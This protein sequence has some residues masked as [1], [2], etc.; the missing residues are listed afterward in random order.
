MYFLGK[1]YET[2]TP[3]NIKVIHNHILFQMVVTNYSSN[4]ATGGIIM[5]RV[6]EEGRK[7]DNTFLSVDNV[8]KSY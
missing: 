5:D 1:T 6:V 2:C 8:F 4:R 7:I 3:L